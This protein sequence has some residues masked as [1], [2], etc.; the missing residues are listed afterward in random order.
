MARAVAE[1]PPAVQ[2]AAA[3]DHHVA[4]DRADGADGDR[5]LVDLQPQ[6]SVISWVFIELGLRDTSIDFINTAWPTRWA[7]IGANVTARHSS[8]GDLAARGAADHLASLYEAA[9]LDGSTAWQRF[10]Y[11]T[12]PMLLPI[13]AIVMTFSIIFTAAAGL[14]HHPRRAGEFDLLAM[15]GR[16]PA[17]HPGRATGGK[18][19]AIAVSHDPLSSC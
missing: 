1:Q 4:L 11:I 12:F 17:R 8:R 19:A 14:R 13:L 6:F 5:L 2:V 3:R 10:R 15:L 7:L 16:L 9:L 18:R